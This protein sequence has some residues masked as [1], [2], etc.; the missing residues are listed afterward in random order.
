M[1]KNARYMVYFNMAYSSCMAE[2]S[3]P[4][5]LISDST[6]LGMGAWAIKSS[7]LRTV[8]NLQQM[9]FFISHAGLAFLKCG[10]KVNVLLS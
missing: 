3:Q 5:Q 7:L 6:L 8:H 1:S 9:R 10:R 4:Y 2:S